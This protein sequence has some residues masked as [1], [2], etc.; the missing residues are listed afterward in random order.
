MR[1]LNALASNAKYNNSNL[2][3]G[4]L[5]DAQAKSIVQNTGY[6]FDAKASSITTTTFRNPDYKANA[7]IYSSSILAKQSNITIENDQEMIE[8]EDV[9][10]EGTINIDDLK[11]AM[12][13]DPLINSK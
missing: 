6:N 2:N 5:L 3:R 13:D 12:N 8:L 1:Q 11:D 10:S 4:N 7:T 9:S